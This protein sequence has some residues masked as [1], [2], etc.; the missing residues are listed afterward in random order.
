MWKGTV[1]ALQVTPSWGGETEK[2]DE[3]EAVAG[4]GLRGDYRCEEAQPVAP[5]RQA[6][7]LELET[8]EALRRDHG[9]EIDPGKIRRNILTKGVPLNHLVGREFRIGEAR[10]RG[11]RL[12]DPCEL[13]EELTV[14]GIRSA[15]Q[16][17]GGLRAEVVTSG[18]IL[19]G[20][21]IIPSEPAAPG[22]PGD[23]PRLPAGSEPGS[24]PPPAPSSSPSE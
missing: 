12:C 21:A 24:G 20:D 5:K 3:I 7:L 2:R 16:N 17:R 23:S 9:M 14:E 11:I 1:V 22:N 10:L 13:I 8:I 4:K 15:L 6:T 18:R 19:P